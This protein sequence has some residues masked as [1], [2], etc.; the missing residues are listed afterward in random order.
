MT[1]TRPTTGLK[2]W[3]EKIQRDPGT[4]LTDLSSEQLFYLCHKITLKHDVCRNSTL[5]SLDG[6]SYHSFW[7][8]KLNWENNLSVTDDKLARE[9]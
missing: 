6:F 2:K 3:G 5:I 8:T 4:Q 1:N 9:R 7:A